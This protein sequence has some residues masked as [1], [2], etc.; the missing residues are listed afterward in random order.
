MSQQPHYNM[1]RHTNTDGDEAVQRPRRPN[2]ET[3]ARLLHGTPPGW[4]ACLVLPKNVVAFFSFFLFFFIVILR[5][6]RLAISHQQITAE[7]DDC[8]MSKLT[9]CTALRVR[10][11]DR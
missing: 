7:F 3:E 9:N 5:F 2:P 10:P 4:L 8:F 1:N 6:G 11:R